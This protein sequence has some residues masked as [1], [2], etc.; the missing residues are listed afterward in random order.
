MEKGPARQPRGVT[1]SGGELMQRMPRRP[2][3]DAR[4]SR[5]DKAVAS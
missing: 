2:Q 3:E 5:T 4:S 1:D